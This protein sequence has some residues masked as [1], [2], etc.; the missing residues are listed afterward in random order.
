MNTQFEDFKRNQ[1]YTK[2]HL[3]G[4]LKEYIE[5]VTSKSKSK[6]Q[7]VCPKCSSGLHKDGAFTYYPESETFHCFACGFHGDIFTLYAQI[8]NLD[9][10]REFKQVLE[11]LCQEFNINVPT[12][13]SPPKL[14]QI[15]K[16]KEKEVDNLEEIQVIKQDIADAKNN[17]NR[18]TYLLSRGISQEV[19]ERFGI[20]YLPAWCTVDTRIKSNFDYS[21]IPDF[22]KTAR[23]IIPTSDTSYIARDIR[24]DSLVPQESKAYTK[25]KMGSIHVL[26]L[27][28]L[29]NSDPVFIC[30]GEIDAFSGI[31]QGFESIAL[32]STTMVKKF[33]E[34]LY[35]ETVGNGSKYDRPVLIW[36]MDSD[37]SGQSAMNEAVNLCKKYNIPCIK[38]SKNFYQSK[39]KDFNQF[40]Q[41]EPDLFK[42]QLE[43]EYQRA[44]GFN[45]DKISNR[46]KTEEIP[47][48][49]PEYI[50]AS[51]SQK[52]GE[53]TYTVHCAKLARYIR[54][55]AYYKFV[56]QN[57]D[58]TTIRYWYNEKLGI[59]EQ[60]IDEEIKGRIK[61]YIEDF[62]YTIVR[63]RDIDEVFYLLVNDLG[64]IT[65]EK[66][67]ENQNI[68]N[69]ENGTLHLD[70]MKLEE[71]TPSDLCTIQIKSKYNAQAIETPNFDKF[72]N[73]LSNGNKDIQKLL[74][75]VMGATISNTY[76]YRFKKALFMLGK[77]NTGKS[78]LRRFITSLLGEENTCACSIQA[79]EERFGG[80]KIFN[81]RLIGATDMGSTTMST[82]D[83]FKSLSGGDSVE[84]E[85]KGKGS[86]SETFKGL[87]WFTMNKLPKI[88]SNYAEDFY[89]RVLIVKCN[90]VI[91]HEDEDPL[92]DEK[93]LA[94]SEGIINKCLQALKNAI[95]RGYKFTEPTECFEERKQY[96]LENNPV[97]IFYNECCVDRPQGET[98]KDECST[99]KMYDVF[100]LFCK[101]NGYYC[102]SNIEFRKKM[103]HI[104]DANVE[105]IIKRTSQNT[106][107]TFTLSNSAKLEYNR[108]Y[109][110]DNTNKN[111]TI[112]T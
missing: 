53:V 94:E 52:T 8:N 9:V 26:N 78:T 13:E 22:K 62:D 57:I 95:D 36:A 107:Y 88:N 30:E 112:L 100:R 31:Q 48:D 42:E 44:K 55:N 103:A 83:M 77:S 89:N 75:E 5:R 45:Y 58:G 14:K 93:L 38:I 51:Y 104:L 82:L 4:C 56:K 85:F 109:G 84:V 27:E 24:P 46:T 10:I 86:F 40:L 39:Y 108:A 12:Y 16:K 21:R 54:D 43:K 66:F 49:I 67:N 3:K 90:N 101:Q 25:M 19:Q 41:F 73:T 76:G 105:D 35:Y 34:T 61:A 29:K 37:N 20:G 28:S 64:A 97:Q 63:K 92:L 70:T 47:T 72:M 106:Y 65:K 2:N 69:F 81:K 17:E 6:N 1:E 11:G 33:C 50:K 7:Y 32:G 111:E 15:E 68:I 91:S 102:I 18:F 110:Y 96:S 80:S 99:K 59:Y 98:I 87:M 74:M 71:H 23:C 79:I 60:V